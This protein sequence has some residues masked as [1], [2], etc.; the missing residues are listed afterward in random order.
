LGRKATTLKNKSVRMGE[1]IREI[2][3]RELK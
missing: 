3:I 2:V 1:E